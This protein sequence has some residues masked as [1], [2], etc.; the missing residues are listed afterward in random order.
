[1]EK[2]E[3]ILS[4]RVQKVE[5]RS[6]MSCLGR[7][8]PIPNTDQFLIFIEGGIHGRGEQIISLIHEIAHIHYGLVLED[9]K[10]VSKVS[11][12]TVEDTALEYIEANPDHVNLL[13][14][15][16]KNQVPT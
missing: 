12:S 10:V 1:V 6:P 14:E 15:R 13:Y 3:G 2:V 11:E 5:F 8:C 4:T 7:C 16:L 9:G